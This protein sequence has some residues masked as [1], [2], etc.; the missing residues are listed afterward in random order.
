MQD[1]WENLMSH[2]L[3]PRTIRQ[4][5]QIL[6]GLASIN[7]Y[8]S[9][10][11]IAR[12]HGYGFREIMH[13]LVALSSSTFDFALVMSEIFGFGDTPAAR[14]T[15]AY[16]R[17]LKH[18]TAVRHKKPDFEVA[19]I[20]VA[21][22]SF[23]VKQ[24][25]VMDL[26]FC[27]LRHFKSAYSEN[28]PCVMLVAP[29]SGHW[30]SFINDTLK[31]LLEQGA[32]VYV[33]DWRNARDVPKAKG[34]FGVREPITYL[35]KFARF[36]HKMTGQKLH[37]VSVCQPCWA[38]AA[39]IAI[40]SKVND[41]AIPASV[42]LM[43][44]P[45]NPSAAPNDTFRNA[46]LPLE[47]FRRQMERVSR[48]HP[49]RGRSVWASLKQL[50]GFI[51]PNIKRH[52]E[53]FSKNIHNQFLGDHGAVDK[54]ERFYDGFLSVL[55]MPAEFVCGTVKAI[56]QD[57]LLPKGKLRWRDPDSKKTHE[58]NL[59]DIKKTRLLVV[60]GE[61]DD[62]CKPGQTSA[63]L[64]LCTGLRSFLK[65]H[66]CQPRVGHYGVF[67]GKIWRSEI[68][69]RVMSHIQIAEFGNDSRPQQRPASNLP[70]KEA[71]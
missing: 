11:R 17:T 16:S 7:P 12:D 27:E 21:G 41:P 48:K 26:P 18:A 58:V 52:S 33:T 40:L 25:V 47:F 57:L 49:G 60:E 10:T 19:D 6:N 1:M 31:G 65:E 9:P 4:N 69:P 13:E 66:F 14:V 20:V 29:L 59:R 43:A 53:A 63:V 54:H 50:T 2:M 56:Y 71:A 32:N 42:T 22:Q 8:A 37:I 61:N 28:G 62:I 44:G 24:A 34:R 70:K 15:K 51:V 3:N 55:D 30:A 23:S 5:I 35:I 46:Q 38:T 64:D 45:I 36:L 39:A 68:L 67:S